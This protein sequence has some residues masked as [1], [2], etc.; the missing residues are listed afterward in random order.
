MTLERLAEAWVAPYANAVHLL[1]TRDWLLELDPDAGE[2]LRIAALTHD[3]ERNFPDSPVPRP[4]LPA[5]EPAYRN[6]HQARSAEIVSRWLAEQG[7]GEELRREVSA[8][9]QTHEWGGSPQADLLQAADS[10]SFLETMAGDAAGWVRDGRFTRQRTV[11]QLR[12]MLSRIR[13][14]K[15][16]RL[17]QPFYD[18]A[19]AAVD[20][21]PGPSG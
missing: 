21:V 12:W 8:I 2:A 17:A 4:D 5:N 18:R 1:R 20:A 10:I 19:L 9:V 3:I 16:R 11:E 14:P 7:A 15:A 6:A 13:V